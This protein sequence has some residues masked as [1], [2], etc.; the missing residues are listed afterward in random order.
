MAEIVDKRQKKSAVVGKDGGT[1]DQ[2]EYYVHYVDCTW[3][4][5]RGGRDVA[6]PARA[7]LRV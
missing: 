6:A 5:G 2:F 4:R 1:P 7:R 3:G